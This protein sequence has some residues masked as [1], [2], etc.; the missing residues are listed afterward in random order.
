MATYPFQEIGGGHRVGIE[1]GD[2]IA[3]IVRNYCAARLAQ[4]AI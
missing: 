1:T 4:L 2:E 3:S